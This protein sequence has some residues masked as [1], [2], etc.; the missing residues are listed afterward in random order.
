MGTT[1]E[2]AFTIACDR[3]DDDAGRYPERPADLRDRHRAR[4]P[5]RVRH[6]PIFQ[7]TAEAQN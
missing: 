4:P 5:G 7:N 3:Y 1:E 2:Q 6:L